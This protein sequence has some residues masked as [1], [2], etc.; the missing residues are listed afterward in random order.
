ML[1][2]VLVAAVVGVVLI[3]LIVRIAGDN[4]HRVETIRGMSGATAVARSVLEEASGRKNLTAGER[5]GRAGDYQWAVVTER[6]GDV[7][8]APE[9]GTTGEQAASTAPPHWTLFWVE[10]AVVSPDG[11]TARLAAH[12]LGRAV[13]G[14]P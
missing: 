5:R 6:L 2:E 14:P 10:V 9:P 3:V 12:R 11:R 4:R 7:I 8:P 1:L 13:R